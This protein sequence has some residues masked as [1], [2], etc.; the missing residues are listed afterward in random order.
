LAG[1][2]K[3]LVIDDHPAMGMSLKLMLSGE[4]EV[5]IA[6]TPEDALTRLAAGVFDLVLCD[7]TMPGMTGLELHQKV[8]GLD[9]A[10]AARFV[11][12]TGG[13]TSAAMAR[14]IEGSR[15]RVLEKPF[16]PEL[17]RALLRE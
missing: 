3:V 5:E 2:K 12:M 17:L 9:P 1:P 13:A 11:L 14:A 16:D 8:Q 6:S 15:L 7:V 4:H 10:A